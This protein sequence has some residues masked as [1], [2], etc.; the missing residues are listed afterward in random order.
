M[1][2]LLTRKDLLD[3]VD[4]TKGHPRGTEGLKRVKDF[5]HKQ[6]EAC[7]KIILRVMQSQLAHCCD[8]DPM[9]IWNDLITIHSSC[10]CSTTIALCCQFHHLRLEH[11]ETMSTYITHVW[12]LAFLLEETD[13]NVTDDDIILAITLGL[14]HL[15]DPFPI[16][17]D[18]TSDTDYMLPHVIAHLVNEYQHQH[19]HHLSQP[20]TNP[21]NVAMAAINSTPHHDLA[22]FGCG[23][24]GHYQANCPTHSSI[25]LFRLGLKPK[26]QLSQAQIG[27]AKMTAWEGFWPGF[28]IFQARAKP[29]GRGFYCIF[30]PNIWPKGNVTELSQLALS[31]FFTLTVSTNMEKTA[32]IVTSA[33]KHPS[34]N[35]KPTTT[36]LEHSERA[37]LPSQQKKINEY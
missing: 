28:E 35:P 33:P 30:G 22:D 24:K 16:S 32:G 19:A 26:S 7:A 15:Y 17:L 9:I 6:L 34:R 23:K 36:L 25:V 4:G 31:T 14:S 37:A 2:A 18:A 12:H 11:S 21:S 27:Q 3:Y 10:G 8:M 1:E 20:K 5:Y 29:S 13:V